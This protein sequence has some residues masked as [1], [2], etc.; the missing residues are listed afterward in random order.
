MLVHDLKGSWEEDKGTCKLC[1]ATCLHNI[2]RFH[3]VMGYYSK[4]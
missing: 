2:D 1:Y 3:E 4:R